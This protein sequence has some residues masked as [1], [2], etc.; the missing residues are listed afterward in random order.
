MSCSSNAKFDGSNHY[1]GH[2]TLDVLRPAQ[3][4]ARAQQGRRTPSKTEAQRGPEIVTT[5]KAQ[6][7]VPKKLSPAPL[8]LPSC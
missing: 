3:V 5:R 4:R 8:R 2:E 6:V 7:I 1:F